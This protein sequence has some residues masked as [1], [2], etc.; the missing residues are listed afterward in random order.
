MQDVTCTCARWQ[1]LSF[2]SSYQW[3]PIEHRARFLRRYARYGPPLRVP[4]RSY[5]FLCP[6]CAELLRVFAQ[7]DAEIHHTIAEWMILANS[8]V[9]ETVFKV[10][11]GAALLRCHAPPA[12]DRT[13]E[14]AATAK[15]RQ[16]RG[17]VSCFIRSRLAAGWWVHC[18][19]GNPA[20]VC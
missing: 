8:D 5:F 7:D 9:A 4:P 17:R 1:A 18:R 16:M 12:V 20:R 6:A 2:L 19:H 15:V 13:A 10:F 11:P 3:T 14:I